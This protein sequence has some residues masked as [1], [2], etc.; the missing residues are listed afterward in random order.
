MVERPATVHRYAR[1]RRSEIFGAI[2]E[3]LDQP[4]RPFDSIDVKVVGEF[5]ARQR[6]RSADAAGARVA[7]TVHRAMHHRWL[8]ADVFHDVDLAATRPADSVDVVAEHPA[9]RPE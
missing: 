7:R 5:A 4:W 8:S 1:L 9:R 6:V 2:H 3:P